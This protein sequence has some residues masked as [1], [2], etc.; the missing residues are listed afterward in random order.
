MMDPLTLWL[1][2]AGVFNTCLEVIKFIQKGRKF[3]DEYEDRLAKF[4]TTKH[5]L[6]SWSNRIAKTQ[7]T[8]L[9]PNFEYDIEPVF[10]ALWQLEQ[11]FTKVQNCLEKYEPQVQASEELALASAHPDQQ[12]S[13]PFG[14]LLSQGI[15]EEWN[16][17]RKEKAQ[18]REKQTKIIQKAK[19]VLDAETLDNLFGNIE[20][21]LDFLDTVERHRRAISVDH[22]NHGVQ[23]RYHSFGGQ[24]YPLS[25]DLWADDA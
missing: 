8:L 19:L 13:Q 18:Q 24:V 21:F 3:G 25:E 6:L 15:F 5:R 7:D 14:S 4:E 23:G 9:Q 1:D 16:K 12:S 11:D 22:T 10:I 17:S 2:V 20:H